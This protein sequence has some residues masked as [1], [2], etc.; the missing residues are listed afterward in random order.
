VK[1]V[2]VQGIRL[3]AIGL[4][5]WQ[6][7]SFEWGYGREYAAG[8]AAA[9]VERAVELGVDLFDTAE[10]YGFGRS[11]RILGVALGEARSRAFIA[12]KLLPVLPLPP[13]VRWRAHQSAR[14][15]GVTT[16]DLYQ[17]HWPNPLFSD[18]GTMAGLRSLLEEG[19]I[20][21]AGV[22]NYP[23][24]RWRRAEQALGRPLLSN[25]VVFSLATP[26]AAADQVPYAEANDR[27]VIAYSPLGQGFLAG[28]YRSRRPPDRMRQLSPRF[29]A[30]SQ[31]RGKALLDALVEVAGRHGATPAQV[32]LA[33][34]IA[35]PNTVAIPGARTVEQLE[36][37]V[38][39]GD[40]DLD[41]EEFQR[42]TRES[43]LY[44]G[45][46]V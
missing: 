20:R 36:S 45:R 34:V 12:T 16:I 7:G 14:R 39:A 1:E 15:L 44:A 21:H 25:Q 18:P 26:A 37:N 8:E 42:L 11:E 5:T 4:G 19:L 3:G 13:I 23:V 17:V 29:G 35:H 10:I 41:E 22:S 31:Q 46:L 43:A 38:A 2:E 30:A 9:I 32:A 28:T 6:F 24:D 40:L 27:L 33:W